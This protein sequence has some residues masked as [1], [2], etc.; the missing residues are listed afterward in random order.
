MEQAE[1]SFFDTM[2]Q[3]ILP[4]VRA[5]MAKKLL[6]NGFSQKDAAQRLG[7]SQPAISQYR[8]NLRGFKTRL[9]E[10]N[11]RLQERVDSLARR[12][13]EEA[14]PEKELN[15]ELLEICRGFL[16]EL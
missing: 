12:L 6:E 4:S 7:L 11:P 2:T 9:I 8:R 5:V 1:K 16:A 14:V 15:M 10:A 13:S 3:E